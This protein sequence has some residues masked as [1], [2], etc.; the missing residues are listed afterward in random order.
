MGFAIISEEGELSFTDWHPGAHA[1]RKYL[2]EDGFDGVPFAI[3]T[4]MRGW[5]SD[6][7]LLMP[8]RYR[9]NPVGACMLIALGAGVQPYAGPVAITGFERFPEPDPVDITE[10]QRVL[11]LDLYAAVSSVVLHGLPSSY[12]GEWDKAVRGYAGNVMTDDPAPVIIRPFTGE[13]P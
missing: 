3:A 5:V 6:T 10:R 8:E 12:G 2:G 7:G 9:R 11:L 13:L 1:F 4:D